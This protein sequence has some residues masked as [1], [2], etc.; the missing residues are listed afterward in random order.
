[1]PA[2]TLS[3]NPFAATAARGNSHSVSSSSESRRHTAYAVIVG[4]ARVKNIFVIC[5]DMRIMY[6]F[7]FVQFQLVSVHPKEVDYSGIFWLHVVDKCKFGK[8]KLPVIRLDNG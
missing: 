6:I 2:G 4:G 8:T 1:M 7:D 5:S 3:S